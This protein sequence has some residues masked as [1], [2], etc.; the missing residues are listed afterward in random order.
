MGN[1][2]GSLHPKDAKPVTTEAKSRDGV[3]S[4]C[5]QTPAP[6]RRNIAEYITGFVD[7]EG[8]F[9]VTFNVREKAK[10]GLELRPSFSVSQN[11]ERSQILYLM[12][13]YFGCGY[14]RPNHR[15]KTLKYE[16]RDHNDLMLKIIPHFERYPLLSKKHK[17]FKLFKEICLMIDRKE[18]LNRNGFIRIIELAYQMNGSGKRKRS[19]YELIKLLR[20]DDI[21]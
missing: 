9:T 5:H 1:T 10:L 16:V 4:S 6:L 14:I 21:V 2:V 7:G 3:E 11:K 20:G 19:K 15:D 12:Q 13:K 8:C 18:H 17:D